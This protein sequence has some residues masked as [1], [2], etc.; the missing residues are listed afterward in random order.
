VC[1]AGLNSAHRR[2]RILRKYARFDTDHILPQESVFVQVKPEWQIRQA[3]SRL[4]MDRA[5]CLWE[6]ARSS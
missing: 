1:D 6:S 5:S 3:W 2:L 4:Q